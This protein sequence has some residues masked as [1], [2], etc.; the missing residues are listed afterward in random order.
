M[1]HPAHDAALLLL[2]TVHLH[3][4][5]AG[6]VPPRTHRRHPTRIVGGR[7]KSSMNKR[8]G[9]VGQTDVRSARCFTTSARTRATVAPGSPDPYEIAKT[10]V[11]SRQ[12][13]AS[14]LAA[15]AGT[16][17]RQPAQLFLPL[18]HR[19]PLHQRT[20]CGIG[21]EV[22]CTLSCLNTEL[23]RGCNRCSHAG[24]AQVVQSLLG[25]EQVEGA[26]ELDVPPAYREAVSRSR[27]SGVRGSGRG[28]CPRQPSRRGRRR[29]RGRGRTRR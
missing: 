9:D 27:P 20:W 2:P 14:T 15:V 26:A 1:H 5:L 16:A 21:V 4:R 18:V 13:F 19:L 3:S 23:G 24:F 17:V 7:S 28:A 6:W 10:N 12:L 22:N 8:F 29:K 25:R 11:M